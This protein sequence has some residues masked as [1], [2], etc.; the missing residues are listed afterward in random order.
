MPGETVPMGMIHGRFQPFHNGHLEYLRAAAARSRTLVV[1]ITNPDPTH[2]R[3]EP[4]DPHRSGDD[5]NPFPYHLRYRMVGAA[6]EAAG[7]DPAA[8]LRVPFPVHQPDLWPSYVPSGT[9]QFLRVFSP[10][11]ETKQRRLRDAGFRVEV[12]PH[13]GHKEVSGT[14]VRRRLRDDGDW[15]ALVPPGVADLLESAC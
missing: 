14:E 5:A 4:A 6:L 7:L 11:E 15:R 3:D 9:V 10:W 13:V 2:I 8:V 1:G 12:L